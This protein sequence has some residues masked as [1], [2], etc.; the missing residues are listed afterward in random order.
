MAIRT[1]ASRSFFLTF[2]KDLRLTILRNAN[3]TNKFE[4]KMFVLFIA[5]G[6]IAKNKL[7]NN[8]L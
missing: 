7:N 1:E 5:N 4:I 6:I 2:N 3:K 8:I